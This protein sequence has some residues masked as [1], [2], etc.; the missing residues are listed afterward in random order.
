MLFSDFCVSATFTSTCPKANGVNQ[1]CEIYLHGQII[2]GDV[3][4]LTNVI[5][6]PPTDGTV[7]RLLIL[8]SPGGDVNEALLLTNVV[9]DALLQTANYSTSDMY[10]KSAERF[11]TYIC[12]SS[13]V[14]VLMSGVERNFSNIHGGGL[15]LHRPYF[16]AKTYSENTHPSVIAERQHHAMQNAREY[17]VSEGFPDRLIEIMMNRSSKEIYWL[18][19]Q[20]WAGV[21][22]NAAWFEEMKISRCGFDPLAETRVVQAMETGNKKAEKAA[23]EEVI[24][25]APCVGSLVRNAQ[26]QMRR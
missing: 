11:P 20:D 10:L 7:Y 25:T 2:E 14:L 15:G 6:M 22:T 5:K 24:R 1:G 19:L 12:A 8:D 23:M 13:C 21:R 17:L 3:G 26:N 18:T 16:S 9:R 4:R